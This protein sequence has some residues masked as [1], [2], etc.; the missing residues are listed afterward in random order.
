MHQEGY[1]GI[2][3]RYWGADGQ[4]HVIIDNSM[5][6]FL[7]ATNVLPGSQ[8]LKLYFVNAAGQEIG[9]PINGDSLSLIGVNV[10]PP[11]I[12]NPP[13]S[14]ADWSVNV[15]GAI[16]SA[17]MYQVDPTNQQAVT[18]GFAA[19]DPNP[20]IQLTWAVTCSIDGRSAVQVATGQGM[21]GSYT[22]DLADPLN[23]SHW[24]G[25][26]DFSITFSDG[27]H[28]T[29]TQTLVH[30][31]VVQPG[32][33]GTVTLDASEVTSDQLPSATSSAGQNAASSS[34]IHAG[35]GALAISNQAATQRNLGISSK[36]DLSDMTPQSISVTPVS[37]GLIPVGGS[38]N[39]PE[40]QPPVG[41]SS[42]QAHPRSTPQTGSLSA[43]FPGAAS[44]EGRSH[45]VGNSRRGQHGPGMLVI[46]LG[47]GVTGTD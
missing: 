11:A 33:T 38:L 41:I 1:A 37:P 35:T 2:A 16:H 42:R 25:V 15:P 23:P 19:T 45:Y 4:P 10:N 5:K 21:S 39:G 40:V 3:I 32:T 36:G 9:D 26:L 46:R 34:S 30:V 27:Q 22:V 47:S 17:Y 12:S 24:D 28:A 44:R 43:R 18:L 14:I 29:P 13:P 8:R 31:N 20:A 6:G 7:Q